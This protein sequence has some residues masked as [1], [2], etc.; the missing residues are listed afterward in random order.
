[1]LNNWVETYDPTIE[2]SYRKWALIDNQRCMLDVLDTAGQ[3][4]YT[5]LRDMWIKDG[6]AFLL[7]YS[8]SS[9]SSFL[10]IKKFYEQILKVKATDQAGTPSALRSPIVCI[11]GNKAD[12]VVER[13]VSTQ[14]GFALAKALDCTFVEF[15]AKKPDPVETAFYDVVR[16]LRRQ[17]ELHGVSEKKLIKDAMQAVEAQTPQTPPKSRRKSVLLPIFSFLRGSNTRT[18]PSQP[19]DVGQHAKLN[20]ILVQTARKDKK[21][22][23]KKLLAMGADPNGHS[24][25]DGSPLYASVLLG[26]VK[27]VKLLLDNGATVNAQGFHDSTALEAAAIEG[28]I[29]LIEL[30]LERGANIE[31]RSKRNGTPL[32]AA[33]ARGQVDAVSVLIQ[34]GANVDADGGIYGTAL[35]AAAWIGNVAI[36]TLLLNAGAKVNARAGSDATPLQVAAF[37]GRAEIVRLLLI[38]G[39]SLNDSKGL[40]GSPLKAASDNSHFD[41]MKLL[42]EAGASPDELSGDS[43][44]FQKGD[45]TKTS[46]EWPWA[47]GTATADQ[48]VQ[49]IE[50]LAVF[51][52]NVEP[53]A[54]LSKLDNNQNGNQL[55]FLSETL[56]S[57]R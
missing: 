35:K 36:A 44:H 31:A 42:Y 38:R 51:D 19:I 56:Q 47:Q 4:E 18:A 53:G 57:T 24:V 28:H 49:A 29:P 20:Q 26:K 54:E 13:E 17:R 6:E 40:Y 33:A 46:F 37:A 50:T 12:R 48:M 30:L 52:H 22:E 11:V 43:K 25:A 41:V 8:I 14:E 3:E 7:V 32:L 5:A 16:L 27:M 21:R 45:T 9:R 15:T 1:M 39:A 10:R 55:Q 34:R 23:V 2:E